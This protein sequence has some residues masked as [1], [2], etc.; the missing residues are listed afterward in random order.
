MQWIKS[1]YIEVL[2]QQIERKRYT[3]KCDKI[4]IKYGDG[5]H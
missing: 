2:Y 1:Y 5:I 3:M 4:E